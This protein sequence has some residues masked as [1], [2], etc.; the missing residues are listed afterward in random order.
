M[1]GT[2]NNCEAVDYDPSRSECRHDFGVFTGALGPFLTAWNAIG[3]NANGRAAEARQEQAVRT[4]RQHFA[5]ATELLPRIA[6]VAALTLPVSGVFYSVGWA[7]SRP[8]QEGI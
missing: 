5:A 4:L 1:R 3:I 8:A 7:L 2:R 6:N